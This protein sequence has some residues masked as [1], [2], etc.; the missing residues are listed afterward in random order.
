MQV[1]DD[2]SDP[3]VPTICDPQLFSLWECPVGTSCQCDFSFFGLLCFV[4]SCPPADAV[5][6]G[7]DDAF[8]PSSAPMCDLRAEA[9]H[10]DGIETGMLRAAPAVRRGEASHRQR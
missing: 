6:C 5:S 10:G 3:K 4:Y 1:K 2:D 8:C 7:V 9:C